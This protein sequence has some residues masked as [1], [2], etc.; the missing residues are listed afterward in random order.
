VNPE[1]QQKK[2]ANA[3]SINELKR[4]QEL[5]GDLYVD[6]D[7]DVRGCRLYDKDFAAMQAFEK[8]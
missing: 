4:R 8:N 1:I 7:D 6:E 3:S 5:M 2:G